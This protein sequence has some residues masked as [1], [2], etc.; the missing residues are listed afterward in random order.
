MARDSTGRQLARLEAGF[1]AFSF[2]LIRG[3]G[4]ERFEAV[5]KSGPGDSGLYTVISTDPAEVADEL[6]RAALP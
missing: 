4:K 3:W 5:R 1:P 2:R 6:R